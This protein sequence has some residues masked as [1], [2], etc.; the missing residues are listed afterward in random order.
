MQCFKLVN[1]GF[2][3]KVIV[4]DELPERLMQGIRTREVA[5]F[6]RRWAS[7]LSEIGSTRQVFKTQTTVGLDRSYTYK[8]TPIGKEPC[9]Y[10]LEY[11]ELNRDKERWGEICEYLRLNVGPEVRLKEK[12]EE[13][14]SALAAN[15]TLP[16]EIEPEDV[17]VI[18]VPLEI[19]KPAAEIVA[20]GET[21][22]ETESAPKK[23]MG[24][25]K[26]VAVA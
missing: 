9:F 5:G 3:D 8:H 11:V 2:V 4:F 7:W 19:Q 25:P 6:P 13:M 14:A 15:P 23:K 22:V 18:L 20:E 24:R 21:L 16:L 17:P 1:A 12:I 26:K 10:V